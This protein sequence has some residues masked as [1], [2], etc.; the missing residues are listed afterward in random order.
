MTWSSG[1][2]DGAPLYHVESYSVPARLVGQRAAPPLG[3]DEEPLSARLEALYRSVSG[4][5]GHP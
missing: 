2:V 1:K 3:F 5:E 4:G